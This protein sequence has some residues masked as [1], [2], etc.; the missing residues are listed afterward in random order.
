MALKVYTREK[1]NDDEFENYENISKT[2]HSH[3]GYR[4]L[5]NALDQIVLPRPGGDH[6]C[7]VMKPMWDSW[8][9]L[10]RYNPSRRFSEELLKA[11]IKQL[12]IALD[13][14]HTECK[15]VHTGM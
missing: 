11:G 3:P 15:L 10:L 7:L 1:D 13:C 12:F 5:R 6:R 2:N 4:H 8:R 9:D 14:L